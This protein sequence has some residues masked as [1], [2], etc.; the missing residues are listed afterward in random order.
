VVV[1][2]IEMYK[3]EC[4]YLKSNDLLKRDPLSPVNWEAKAR[5][6]SRACHFR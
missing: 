6:K 1:G 5:K 4:V 2:C 3:Y